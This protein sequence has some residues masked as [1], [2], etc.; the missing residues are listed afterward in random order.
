MI[1]DRTAQRITRCKRLR[2]V[3]IRLSRTSFTPVHQGRYMKSPII[4]NW[5][6]KLRNKGEIYGL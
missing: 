6:Y 1:I 5:S 4:I 2:F 3:Q